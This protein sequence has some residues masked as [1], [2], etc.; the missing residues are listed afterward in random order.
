MAIL[1]NKYNGEIP[2]DTLINYF[3]KITGRIFYALPLY[4]KKEKTLLNHIEYLILELNACDQLMF[5][6]LNI[7]ELLVNLEL[8][9][10]TTLPHKQYKSQVFKTVNICSDIIEDLKNKI[11]R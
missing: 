1:E 9:K 4:E 3:E 10:S 5:K 11:G 2:C 6:Q 7:F 8:L